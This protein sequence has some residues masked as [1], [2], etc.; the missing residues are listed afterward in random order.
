M[1]RHAFVDIG[2]TETTELFV[3]PTNLIAKQKEEKRRIE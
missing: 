2:D 3:D 1:L